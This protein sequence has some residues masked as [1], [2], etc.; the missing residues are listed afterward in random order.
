VTK[1]GRWLKFDR[2]RE[3]LEAAEAERNVVLSGSSPKIDLD[4][5]LEGDAWVCR[6]GN[7]ERVEAPRLGLLLGDGIQNLRAALDHLVVD[8]A[9]ID[10]GAWPINPRG[11][12]ARTQFPV[13]SKKADFDAGTSEWLLGL[14]SE[15]RERIESFQPYETGSDVLESLVDISNEDKHRVVP[16]VASTDLA[17]APFVQAIADCTLLRE[18]GSVLGVPCH[19]PIRQSPLKEHEEIL[20]LPLANVGTRAQVD[21]VFETLVTVALRDGRNVGNV[22]AQAPQAV[23]EI[24][25]A[26]ED[27]L[28]TPD[29]EQT[30]RVADDAYF[31]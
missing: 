23:E 31:G 17:T 22:L 10:S 2:A 21:I 24:L 4:C 12:L 28:T 15:H 25:S 5:R 6:T 9:I 18:D 1:A 19:L 20:R 29:A 16:T 8:L 13:C 27:D 7:I 26:F 3:H 30:R 11:R 14:S